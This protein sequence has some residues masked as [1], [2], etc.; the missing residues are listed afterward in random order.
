MHYPKFLCNRL[1]M[2][3]QMNDIGLLKI[4]YLG[5]FEL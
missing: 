1:S 3:I 4:F 5:T 2:G